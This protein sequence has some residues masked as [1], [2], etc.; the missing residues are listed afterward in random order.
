MAW[1]GLNNMKQNKTLT[2][3]KK[4][5][6]E[7]FGIKITNH[8]INGQKSVYYK[9]P[10]F[11]ENIWNFIEKVISQTKQ[12]LIEE[13]E[14]WRVEQIEWYKSGNNESFKDQ[15]GERIIELMALGY[16]LKKLSN[17]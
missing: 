7:K 16:Q 14:K 8:K 6:E 17:K 15:A 11:Y 9:L 12:E 13:I 2:E 10:D 3:I 1:M 5:F 4:E